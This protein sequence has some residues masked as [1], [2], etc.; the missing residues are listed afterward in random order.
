MNYLELDWN[1]GNFI[2]S[3]AERNEE[4]YHATAVYDGTTYEGIVTIF[5]NPRTFEREIIKVDNV[6]EDLFNRLANIIKP[7]MK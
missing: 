5:I 1:C 4:C 2:D 6:Y 3:N 7:C